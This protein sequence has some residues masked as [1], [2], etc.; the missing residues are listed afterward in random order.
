MRSENG[1]NT[2]YWLYSV[3]G[4]PG[5]AGCFVRVSDRGACREEIG[6]LSGDLVLLSVYGT[7][8]AIQ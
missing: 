1:G 7:A 6:I 2:C 4:V 3:D 8:T 5:L